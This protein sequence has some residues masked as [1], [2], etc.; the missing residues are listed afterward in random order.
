MDIK[1]IPNEKLHVIVKAAV[2][3][4]LSKDGYIIINVVGSL[5]EITV[6]KVPVEITVGDKL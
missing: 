4:V 3:A 1:E 2:E 6:S 5:A